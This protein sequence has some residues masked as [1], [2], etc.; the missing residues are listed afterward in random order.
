MPQPPS[1]PAPRVCQ[2]FQLIISPE[3]QSA[4][5]DSH[6]SGRA[7]WMRGAPGNWVGAELALARRKRAQ[8]ATTRG[9]PPPGHPETPAQN[10]LWIPGSRREVRS[11]GCKLPGGPR[12]ASAAGRQ[13]PDGIAA[14]A[15]GARVSSGDCCCFRNKTISGFS[16]KSQFQPRRHPGWKR[17]ALILFTAFA[18]R[19]VMASSKRISPFS[20]TFIRV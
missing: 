11:W 7:G 6:L 18:R 12:V 17:P 19:G 13:A 9:P 8:T 2:I 16:L 14:R 10:R 20:R 4:A 3:L 1:L 5:S 15:Q